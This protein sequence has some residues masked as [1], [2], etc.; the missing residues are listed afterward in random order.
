VDLVSLSFVDDRTER[1]LAHGGVADRKPAGLVGK[2]LHEFFV[3]AICHEVPARRHADLP[4]MEERTPSREIDRCFDLGVI[5]DEEGG[6][7]AER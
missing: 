2:A 3:R 5:E 1:D 7:P 4:L 6:I